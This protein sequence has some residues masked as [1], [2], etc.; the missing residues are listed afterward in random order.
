MWYPKVATLREVLD[1]IKEKYGLDKDPDDIRYFSYKG[2]EID[3]ICIPNLMNKIA[4][5]SY[6]LIIGQG[7]ITVCFLKPIYKRD[8]VVYKPESLRIYEEL[9]SK[10]GGEHEK[11][12]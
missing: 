3:P 12:F 9:Q 5:V 1:E 10:K 11:S 8:N 4:T 2:I 6:R 7:I